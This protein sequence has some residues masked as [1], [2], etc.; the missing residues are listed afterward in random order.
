MDI[1]LKEKTDTEMV[2]V[3]TGVTVPFIN[4][5]RRICM[6]E[7]PKLA[8]EYVNMYR[9]DARMFDEVLAHRLGLV[10]LKADPEFIEGLKMPE[11][12]DCE[13]YC[14]E[15]SVS[16]ALKKKGPGVVYSRDLLSE[17]PAVKPVYPDIPL[18]K[19]G[20]EDE[21]EL[22]AVAQLGMGRDHAKWE[23]TTACAYKY[24]PMITFTGECD[25]CLECVD[26]CPRGVLGGESGKPEVLDVENCSM[27]KSCVRACDKG[28]IVVGYE[29]GKFIFRIET[30]GSVDPKDVLLKACDILRD[31][32]ER[33]ITFCEGG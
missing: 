13:E 17:T 14:S 29:E 31:K 19:L 22:E 1:A 11:E 32:A 7:V 25:E 3:V 30:D 26:A 5:I 8:I 15:C 27:C 12:C 4:A 6:M 16:F 33:V 2:F 24:Y 21:V 20:D 18:V 28:A 10:P 9:N 23:P